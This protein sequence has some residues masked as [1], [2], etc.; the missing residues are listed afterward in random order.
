[1]AANGL[2]NDPYKTT[3]PPSFSST[4]AAGSVGLFESPQD[5]QS[6]V[7]ASAPRQQW[8]TFDDEEEERM[9]LRRPVINASTFVTGSSRQPPNV[10]SREQLTI[11]SGVM[12]VNDA[13]FTP[14]PFLGAEKNRNIR[15][16]LDSGAA[17]SCISEAFFRS[18]NLPA[19]L[20][21]AP[22]I[23]H[24]VSANKSPMANLGTVDLHI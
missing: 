21:K 18:L 2:V 16:L 4:P 3:M 10:L 23:S 20:L 15:A 19:S 12:A 11:P 9:P 5:D 17:R 7:P 1:M 13:A 14:K 8:M 24:L 6:R 22:G